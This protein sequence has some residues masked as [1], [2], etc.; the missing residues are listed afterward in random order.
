M[1]RLKRRAGLNA[2]LLTTSAAPKARVVELRCRGSRRGRLQQHSKILC[3]NA[4]RPIGK[5]TCRCREAG[6]RQSLRGGRTCLSSQ[7]ESAVK[8][9]ATKARSA[10]P[11]VPLR[12][13][14]ERGRPSTTG[15]ASCRSSNVCASATG[16]D[17]RPLPTARHLPRRRPPMGAARG[18]SITSHAHGYG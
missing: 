8:P 11:S 9:R 17:A 16:S 1:V 18:P 7:G 2:P 13:Q 3:A 6:S 14:R 15:H 12:R 4:A 10:R 5:Q